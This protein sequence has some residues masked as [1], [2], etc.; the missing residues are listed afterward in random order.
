MVRQH[1]ET[2]EAVYIHIPFCTNKCHY[3][4]FNSY[5]LK[6]QPVDAYLDALEHEMAMVVRATPP[7]VIRTIFVGGGT[8]TVLSPQ[9]MKRFLD[10]VSRHF[11]NR[12]ADVEFTM[13]ANPGTTHPAL[14]KAMRSGGVNRI[15]FGVQSFDDA[16]LAGIGRIHSVDDV[17]Q[18]LTYARDAGFSNISIDL[19]FGLPNQTVEQ[20][21]ASLQRALALGLPH[22]SIYSLK[23]EEHTLFHSL[24]E[25][26]ELPLP[27]ED[28]EVAMFA[29]I[30]E[31]MKSSGYEQYE[32]SNFAK[33][34]FSSKHN[35]VYW[36]NESYYGLGA[37]AH[38]YVKGIRHVNVKAIQAYIDAVKLG[39]PLLESTVV[40]KK[41][42]MEDFMMV[43]LRLLQGIDKRDFF[44]QFG[45]S[46]DDVFGV[47]F[48][49]LLDQQLLETTP[50]GYRLSKQGVYLGNEVFAA[51]LL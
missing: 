9:Q 27:E 33:S 14:L 45:V 6:G 49:R 19:M 4:D 8:P 11:P 26:G 7:G 10:D 31:C 47:V 28:I 16:L 23:V 30:L 40:S 15:S 34:G 20:V 38:G 51:F 5:V 29:R 13:E 32:V 12:S 44:A 1:R 3:C 50:Y 18:S 36:R 17:Y 24:Y 39:L 46:C 25:R 22:Y 41:E 35:T 2:P 42:A 43:G 21:D 37:G 48:R